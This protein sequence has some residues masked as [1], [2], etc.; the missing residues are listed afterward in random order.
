[1]FVA[2]III[3]SR[4]TSPFP[5]N[6]NEMTIGDREIVY[7]QQTTRKSHGKAHHLHLWLLFLSIQLP[8]PY[9][10]CY[11]STLLL[12]V[13]SSSAVPIQIPNITTAHF[14][15]VYGSWTRNA[16][17]TTVTTPRRKSR[18]NEMKTKMNR[19]KRRG[20]HHRDHNSIILIVT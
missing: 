14:K 3:K 9:T 8:S 12:I 1:M 13:V 5:I 18:W 17:A 10:A 7:K 16:P 19:I 2:N 4:A 11:Y 20:D 6:H 15:L